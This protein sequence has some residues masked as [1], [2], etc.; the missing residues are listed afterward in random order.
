MRFKTL[1]LGAA[2]VASFSSCTKNSVTG[3]NQLIL[4]PEGELMSLSQQQYNN[5]LSQNKVIRGTNNAIK[6]EKMGMSLANAVTRYFQ[7]K[8]QGELIRN[9]LW[10]FKL[11]EDRAVNAWCMPGG[12]VVV[13]TGLLPVTQN[14]DAL[15]VVIGH[16]IAHAIANHG[17]ERM[18]QG[19][20]KEAG[21]IALSTLLVSKPELTRQL[22]LSAYGAGSSIGVLLPFSRKQELEAD[23]YGLIFAAMA[24]YN[25]EAA[26][27]FWQR[28]SMASGGTSV[29]ELLS[30]HPSDQTRIQKVRLYVE[31]AKKYKK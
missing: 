11:V 9:Y 14:D 3:R 22:F 16:E 2:L 4:V 17:N 31:E 28:M 13:Y 6:V 26:I 23:R 1:V 21:G 10:D 29:P 20:L 8:G 25:P 27:E 12:K 15:A 7:T 30:T 19:M 5:F 18:S 24:G